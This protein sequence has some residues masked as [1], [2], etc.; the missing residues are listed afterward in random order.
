MSLIFS[1][2]VVSKQLSRIIVEMHNFVTKFG[3]IRRNRQT[4]WGGSTD[5]NPKTCC[6]TVHD[7]QKVCTF[8]P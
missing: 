5:T 7:C 2:L 8:A 3:K 4:L 1:N 6:Q